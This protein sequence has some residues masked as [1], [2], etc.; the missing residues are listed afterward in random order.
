MS[1]VKSDGGQ[2]QLRSVGYLSFTQSCFVYKRS[3]ESQINNMRNDL[4]F[5]K[6]E[7]NICGD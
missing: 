3:H 5:K 1:T 4:S 7:E 6:R 2:N